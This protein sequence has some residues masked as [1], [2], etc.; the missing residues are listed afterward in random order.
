MKLM[1]KYILLFIWISLNCMA[2]SVSDI[3]KL[4]QQGQFELAQEA[5]DQLE[6]S[7]PKKDRVLFLKGLISREADQASEY[8]KQLINKYPDSEYTQ[9]ALLRLAQLKYAQGLYKSSLYIFLNIKDNDPKSALLQE[10]HYWAGLCYLTLNHPD[11]AV[12]HFGRVI[13]EFPSRDVT[14]LAAQELQSLK[15]NVPSLNEAEV[16][17]AH[18]ESETNRSIDEQEPSIPL[19]T[20]SSASSNPTIH[21]AVQTGAYSNQSNAL[22]RKKFFESKGYHVDLRSKSVSGKCLYLV[23]VGD[24]TDESEARSLGQNLNQKFGSSTTLVSEIR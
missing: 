4:I 8:Y 21:Y 11:S 23:W 22:A 20:P 3:V 19:S 2:Q 14:R 13:T 16:S 6:K 7:T 10:S 17:S 18:Y 12:I 15:I 9:K 5:L 24:F 1:T